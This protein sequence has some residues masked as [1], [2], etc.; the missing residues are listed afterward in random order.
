MNLGDILSDAFQ[1][2]LSDFKQML[3][4]GLPYLVLTI[5]TIILNFAIDNSSSSTIIVLALLI[6]VISIIATLIMWG[7]GLSVIRE[8]IK[9]NNQLPELD[10][11]NNFIDGIKYAVVGMVYL[12]IPTVIMIIGALLLVLLA[13]NGAIIGAI[14]I[15]IGVILAIFL[16]LLLTVAVCKLA[17]T[18]DFG[19]VFDFKQVYAISKRIGQPARARA[20]QAAEYPIEMIEQ[21]DIEGRPVLVQTGF[22][23][24]GAQYG[25]GLV[26]QRQDHVHAAPAHFAKTLHKADAIKIW[27]ALM[28]NVISAS[29]MSEAP[30]VII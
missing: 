21:G 26:R 14:I 1:Y 15:L 7:V 18:D 22:I 19:Q 4:L 23:L 13:K 10:I 3:K 12:V 16:S 9:S 2:P 25:I 11:K 5:F 6:N 29:A 27:R 28:K 8:T 17:E 20:D 24:H 30:E